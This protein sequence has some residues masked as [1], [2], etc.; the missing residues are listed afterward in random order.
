MIA[1]SVAAHRWWSTRSPAAGPGPFAALVPGTS[2]SRWSVVRVHPLHLG[3]VPVVLATEQGRR[4]QVDV[5]ARDPQGPS[6]VAQTDRLSLFVV[7]S[8]E[9]SGGD[10]E[11]PTDE[12]Q[13]LGAMVLA[14]ALVHQAAPAGLLTLRECQRQFPRGAFGVPLS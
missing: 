2:L 5:L 14:Q 7:N 1:L 3:A 13:G 6:G 9:H 8:P 11:R 4:Y 10:G 12:E